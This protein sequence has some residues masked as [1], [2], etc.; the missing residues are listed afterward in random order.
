[1]TRY[2]LLPYKQGSKGAM[3]LAD[4]LNGRVLLLEGSKFHPKYDDVIINWGQSRRTHALD[5]VTILNPPEVIK[6]ASNKLTFFTNL[7]EADADI[8]PRFWTSSRDIPADAFPIVCRTVLEGHSG[9]GIVIAATAADLVDAPLYVQYIKKK[10]EY[11]VHV[12]KVSGRTNPDKI[13]A[14][15][16]KARR[17]DVPDGDVNWE[18]RNHDNGFIYVRG[19]VNPPADVLD[20][21]RRALEVSGLDFG[22]V[23]VIYHERQAK[24]YVLEINSAPGIEGSTVDDYAA[25]FAGAIKEEA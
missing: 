6:N 18:V 1:M 7:R 12:G 5:G 13:I 25:Y 20:V 17:R 11:R 23:D 24:A 10:D 9:A 21:A 14:V 16:R 2:R 22:A 8:I 19:G 15:Q 4:A 3:T